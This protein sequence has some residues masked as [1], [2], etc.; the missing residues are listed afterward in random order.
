M[1]AQVI[2]DVAI[3][4]GGLAGL[5]TALELLDSGARVLVLDRETPENLGGLA[6]ESFGGIFAV[7]TPEQRRGG[8]RDSV[9]LARS[10]WLAGAE[11]TGDDGWPRRWADAYVEECRAGIYEW[12]RS[13]GIRFLPVVNWIERG[14]YGPGNSV[15]RFH[16]VWGTG[17]ELVA[18]VIAALER[19]PAAG[20]LELRYGHRVE[21]LLTAGG[22]VIG[23]A[24]RT[25]DDGRPFEVHAE[26][27]VVAGGGF[28]GN[29]EHVRRHWDPDWHRP[30][31]VI[32]NGSHHFA[33]GTLHGAARDA[34]AAVTHVGRMWNYAAG[35]HHPRPRRPGHGLSLV[36]P[37]SALWVNWRGERIGPEPMVHGFDTRRLVAQVCAEEKAYSWQILNRRIAVRELVV[38]GA[39][40]ND[41][42]REKRPL[43]FI[44]TLLRGNRRLVDDLTGSC[45][46]FVTAD[47]LDGL[48]EAMN[49]LAGDDSVD[50]ER[51]KAVVRGYDANLRRGRALRNDD[52]LRRIAQLRQYRGDRLRTCRSQPIED[53]A[54]G[55]LLAIREFILSRKSLGGLQTDLDSRVLG[56]AGFPIPGLYAVGEAAGFGG[57]GMH[58]KRTLEGTFL[59]GCIL[60]ARHAARAIAAGGSVA[61]AP[62]ERLR[63]LAL[64][65]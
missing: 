13:R 15:P 1:T 34:G 42:I 57:G 7:D 38:S 28:G 53:P 32:L 45:E 10:D 16:I 9:E 58:G 12:L 31:E 21:R 44:A 22:R 35:V 49:G 24:G 8:I 55:P 60:T 36:P 51:L 20:R 18:R 40:F 50:R 63:T 56:A 26:H 46:D 65:A 33:D 25:E 23:C 52:Q 62:P 41:A 37:K 54:A 59:G 6:K 27:T 61:P 39:E 4:G 2:T 29:L 3:A 19:H 47:S 43:A 17:S 30:P 11:F 14:L 5:V 64:R 48:A